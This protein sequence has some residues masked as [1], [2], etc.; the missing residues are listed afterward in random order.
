MSGLNAVD[1]NIVIR[2]S[3]LK[4]NDITLGAN[5]FTV[6]LKDAVASLSMDKFAAYKGNG[7]G[8]V[9]INAKQPPYKIATNFSLNAID[10]QP[11][12]RDAASFDK[13]MGKGSLNWDLT[14]SGNSQKSFI[15]ALSGTLAFEFADGAV[16]G[17]N[18]AKRKR[19]N[20]REFRGSI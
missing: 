15:N 12:L 10:A 8:K 5:Q 1:A 2:S 7:K 9:T 4:A 20:K 6:N 17:A 16:T 14:T 11:L 18:I 3:G 13:L 19:A